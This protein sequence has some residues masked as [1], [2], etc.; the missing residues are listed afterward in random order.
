MLN[1]QL[2]LSLKS[3]RPTLARRRHARA[4]WWFQRMRQVV[5]AAVNHPPL[6][7]TASS[8][9]SIPENTAHYR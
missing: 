5:D 7:Q 2:E 4:Q 9:T 3:H 1:G 6:A 8:F